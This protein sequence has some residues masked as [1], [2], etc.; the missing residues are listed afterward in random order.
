MCKRLTA[1][2][3]LMSGTVLAATAAFLIPTA[4]YA[5][6]N[7]DAPGTTVTCSGNDADGYQTPTN[8]V[9][10]NVVPAAVVGQNAPTPSPLVSAGSD[11]VVNNSGTIQSAATAISLG[12]GSTVNNLSS[13]PQRII[14]N[15]DFGAT[16]A[17]QVN[18]F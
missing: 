12:G 2:Q 10:I 6:C 5:D 16:G 7:P 8:G 15:V 3:Y 14:G 18:T 11:S 9:T 17:S 4:A 1:K 13:W